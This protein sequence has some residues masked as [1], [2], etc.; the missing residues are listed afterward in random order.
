M[1][2][3]QELRKDISLLRPLNNVAYAE[4]KAF[5]LALYPQTKAKS[6]KEEK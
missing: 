3:F 4:L 5:Y 2:V 6:Q 1:S